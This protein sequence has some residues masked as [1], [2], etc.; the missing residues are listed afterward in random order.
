MAAACKL[1]AGDDVCGS[2]FWRV[3]GGAERGGEDW[4]SWGAVASG[5]LESGCAYKGPRV[6]EAL[7]LVAAAACELAVDWQDCILCITYGS[8]GLDLGP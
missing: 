2:F 5:L 8:F 4:W 6:E 7:A 3:P 1:R